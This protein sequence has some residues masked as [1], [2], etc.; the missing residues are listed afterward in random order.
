MKQIAT[1]ALMLNLGVA[2]V[3]AQRP[4]KMT[5]QGTAGAGTINLQQPNTNNDEDDFAGTGTL[6]TFTFRNVR[7]IQPLRKRR[8]ALVRAQLNSIFGVCPARAFFASMTGV[9]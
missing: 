6:G 4:V 1:M 2:G 7:A 3:Y 9:Y 8:P 5:F